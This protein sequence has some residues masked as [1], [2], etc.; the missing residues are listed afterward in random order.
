[1]INGA[2]WYHPTFRKRQLSMIIPR[3]TR[4]YAYTHWKIDHSMGLAMEG[5]TR[6]GIIDSVGYPHREWDL[7]L[8]NAPNGDPRCCICW[9]YADEMLEDLRAF[10]ASFD[11]QVDVGIDQRRAQQRG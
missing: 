8:F 3:I 6:G 11:A 5:P 1:V 9:I 7:R 4:A 2:V 10:S